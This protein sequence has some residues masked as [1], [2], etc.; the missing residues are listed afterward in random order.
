M[1]ISNC[2]S[3]SASLAVDAGCWQRRR[4]CRQGGGQRL[5]VC[6]DGAI[7]GR[8]LRLTG[9]EEFQILLQDEEVL[10]AIVAG[11]G[12]HDLRLRGATP[13]VAMLG[14]L[15]RVAVAGDDVAQDPE[16][17]DAG[18][19]AD[20]QRQLEIHLHQRLLHALD[21]GAG[22]LHQVCRWRR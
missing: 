9:V 12:R 7:T 4:R 15:L 13:I 8:E 2:G 1:R 11:Q 21:V 5:D 10:G 22:A 19:V 14:E 17:G 3:L 6:L 20:D 18:D 16:P